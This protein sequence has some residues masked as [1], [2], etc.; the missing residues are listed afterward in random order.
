M[1]AVRCSRGW[2]IISGRHVQPTKITASGGTERSVV[3][4]RPAGRPGTRRGW[5]G[6]R[7]RR[8]VAAVTVALAGVV[9]GSHLL[10]A[11]ADATYSLFTSADTSSA[12]TFSD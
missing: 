8:L 9:A 4:R 11:S 10:G 12:R 1:A 3:V 5:P 7:A 2:I 6:S